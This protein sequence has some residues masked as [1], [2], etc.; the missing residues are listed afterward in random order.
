VFIVWGVLTLLQRAM[1]A[2]ILAL[3]W[4]VAAAIGGA[5]GWTTT[6]L[7]GA[8]FDRAAGRVKLPGSALPLARNLIVFLAKYGLAVAA[9]VVPAEAARLAWWDV[10][11][12]G[13]AAGYFL[14]WL[15]RV[16]AAY[17]KAPRATA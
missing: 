2:P 14:G 15:G 10:T 9:A 11:V 13:L 5:I 12:S 1:G 3:D 8:R 4:V 6:R 7:D 17:L 16:F